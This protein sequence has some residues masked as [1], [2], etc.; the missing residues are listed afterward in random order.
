MQEKAKQ[1][2]E[3]IKKLRKARNLTI[4][5]LAEFAGIDK[6][7]LS[8]I[9]RGLRNPPKPE[10]VHNLADA[11]GVPPTYLMAKAGY[12]EYEG[13]EPLTDEEI[14]K[15]VAATSPAP[16]KAISREYLEGLGERYPEFK[17]FIDFV[18]G[19]AKSSEQAGQLRRV[20]IV[21]FIA[22]G[23]PE[24]YHSLSWEESVM[25]PAAELPGDPSLF[26]VRVKGESMVGSRIEENDI[27][28]I[29]PAQK[30]LL[31]AGDIA[32]VRVG[33]EGITLKEVHNYADGL[34]LRST[35]PD[36]PDMKFDEADIV[37]K[38]IRLVKVQEL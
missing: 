13:E 29:S 3:T 14:L 8:R 33:E 25:L 9:E 12:F 21:G 23:G 5:L 11:L 34:V 1:F 38:A 28:V 24:G 18:V 22:A 4:H 36:F 32:A 20:P 10:A 27:V 37:G 7:H 6:G 17:D 31:K 2:G 15:Q 30:G 16:S 35:N 26:A 19:R